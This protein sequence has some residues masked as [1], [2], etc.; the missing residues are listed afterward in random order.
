MPTATK[1]SW[2]FIRRYPTFYAYNPNSKSYTRIDSRERVLTKYNNYKQ[3]NVCVIFKEISAGVIN[4]DS[5]GTKIKN[6][7]SYFLKKALIKSGLEICGMR[8]I[9]MD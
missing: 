1:E 5:K 4:G 7:L 3:E 2:D 8:M 9:Y 6:S